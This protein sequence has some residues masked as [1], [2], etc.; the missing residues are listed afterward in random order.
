M[1]RAA[2][3]SALLIA[4]LPAT[5]RPLE[6][7]LPPKRDACWERSYDEAHLRAHP[8][9]KV[10]KIR[11]VHKPGNWHAEPHAA[12]YIVLYFNLRQRM[13]THRF[14]YQLGGFCKLQDKG[15]RCVPEWDAGSWRLESGPQG[16]LDIRNGGIVANPNP[17]DAEEIADGAVKIPAKPDDGLWRL[18]P[19]SDA[20]EIE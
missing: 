12:V 9:Q 20:C 2:V 10:A 1:R 7:E 16:A 14:D 8:Q 18:M 4:A 13:T 6:S 3:V 11:L 5:A 19:A 17:Y 15:L